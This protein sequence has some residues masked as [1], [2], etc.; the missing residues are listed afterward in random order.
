MKFAPMGVL[1]GAFLTV[2]VPVRDPFSVDR[3]VLNREMGRDAVAQVL[4]NAIA[5]VWIQTSFRLAPPAGSCSLNRAE[6]FDRAA[7]R[8]EDLICSV[9]DALGRTL[10]DGLSPA[11]RL[12][13]APAELPSRADPA[14]R[15]KAVP[16][17][18]LPL[19]ERRAV[20]SRCLKGRP[21]HSG[22]ENGRSRGRASYEG[23]LRSG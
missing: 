16:R 19:R 11:P 23:G 15:N 18:Q 6:D 20:C 14:I 1:G 10:A 2:A 8:S 3:A 13:V 7:A 5:T 4:Q 17:S 9:K 22:E 12:D 21:R